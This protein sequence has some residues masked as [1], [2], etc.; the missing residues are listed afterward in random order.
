[1]VLES[2]PAREIPKNFLE[3]S[4]S[5]VERSSLKMGPVVKEVR[6]RL[7]GAPP[8]VDKEKGSSSLS[9]EVDKIFASY[10]VDLNGKLT[11]KECKPLIQKV[12]FDYFGLE[13]GV[14]SDALMLDIFEEMD[15]NQNGTVTKQELMGYLRHIKDKDS[16]EK[17]KPKATDPSTDNKHEDDDDLE[18]EKPDMRSV[19]GFLN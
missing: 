1:M 16:D 19:L 3:Q 15:S 18:E 4:I 12:T 9:K 14:A 5:L 8:T 2:S 6:K 11:I 10:D 13:S 7:V 17:N